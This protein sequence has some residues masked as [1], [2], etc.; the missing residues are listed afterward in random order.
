M[1]DSRHIDLLHS[2]DGWNRWRSTSPVQPDLQ[3][4]HLVEADLSGMDLRN[5]NLIEARLGRANLF[6][7]KLE[8][9]NLRDA[10]LFGAKLQET[11]LDGANLRGAN[12]A[13]ADAS[14]AFLSGANLRAANLTDTNLTEASLCGANL[15]RTL[16]VGTNL[17][18][19]D[20]SGSSVYG[21]S[22]W[23]LKLN[24]TIQQNLTITNSG[25]PKIETDR[26]E[27]AQ[28]LYL[29]LNNSEIRSVIDTITSKVVLIL[30][31][32]S[33]ARKSF[34]DA[35]RDALRA[36]G[37][38]PVLFDFE[39]PSHQ[40]TLETVGTLA[41]M[42]RFVVADLTDAKSVLQELAAIVPSRPKL[43]VQ[44]LLLRSQS[45]PG[46]F[47]FFHSFPWVLKTVYYDD[48]RQLVHMLDELVIRQVEAKVSELRIPVLN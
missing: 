23:D 30:G 38:V 20:L 35:V 21:L 48:Q 28:F 17:T 11:R 37:Y 27:L 43:A 36:R 46:M 7:A 32:F 41:H 34:L 40:T 25:Q 22:A 15:I 8:N 29:L 31:R 26:I 12:L 6:R 33:T 2:R 4:A 44:P 13:T 10:N 5:C 14:R 16:L 39:K 19:A 1:A 24:G 42:A 45:E 18:S 47:D 3:E 9:A